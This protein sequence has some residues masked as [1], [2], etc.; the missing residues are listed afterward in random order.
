MVSR[1][2]ANQPVSA[3]PLQIASPTEAF[4]TLGDAGNREDLAALVQLFNR[5]SLELFAEDA[6]A[7]GKLM[8]AIMLNQRAVTVA[9]AAPAVRNEKINGDTA[10]I[11]VK[12][13]GGNW[14]KMYFTKEDGQWKVA[15]D[16]YM[17]EMIRQVEESTK[18]LEKRAD[19]EGDK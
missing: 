19:R 11:E 16:K 8:D 9:K 7:Q 15:M 14:E 10:T 13:A 12:M 2:L 1:A 5:R 18:G 6:R 4:K 3:A 17:E